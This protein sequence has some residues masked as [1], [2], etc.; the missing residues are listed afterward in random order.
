MIRL[1]CYCCLMLFF[2][3]PAQA[4]QAFVIDGDTIIVGG[5]THRL[6]GIDAPEEGQFC[7]TGKV[8]NWPCG[9]ARQGSY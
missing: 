2:V 6:H 5:V 7:K 9:K 1:F 3:H 8:S 4:D